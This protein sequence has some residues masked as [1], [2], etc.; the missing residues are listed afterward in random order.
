MKR[1]SELCEDIRKNIP[2]KGNDKGQGKLKNETQVGWW[3]RRESEKENV[4]EV[5]GGKVLQDLGLRVKKWHDLISAI[6]ECLVA[7]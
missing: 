2:S 3:V 7:V 6:K 5:T 1:E 4:E